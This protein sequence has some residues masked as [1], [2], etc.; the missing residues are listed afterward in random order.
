MAENAPVFYQETYRNPHASRD[1]VFSVA[2]MCNTPLEDRERNVRINSQRDLNWVAVKP[3]H[4]RTAVLCGG[5]PSLVDHLDEIRA[6]QAAGADVFTMNGSSQFLRQHGIIADAQVLAD[7]KP[8]TAELYDPEARHHYIA[9]QC[10]PAMFEQGGSDEVW[11]LYLDEDVERLFPPERKAQGGYAL[12]GGITSV[13]HCAMCLTWALGYR[14]FEVFG[15]DSSNRGVKKH[16]YDQPMN[17]FIPNL[18]VKWAGKTYETSVAMR[19]QAERMT[20][21]IRQL[22]EQDCEVNVHGDGLLPAMINFNAS[23]LTE[24]DKYR[25]LW[26]TELY[27]SFS[28]GEMWARDVMTLLK[29]DSLVLDFGCGSGRASRVLADKGIPVFLMDFAENCRDE[30][31]MDL[32]FLQWDLTQPIPPQAEY[33]MCCDV[34]EHIH[35]DEVETVVSNIMNA[36]SNV[37]FSIATV[38]DVCHDFIGEPLHLTIQPH[39]W[40]KALLG[41]YGNVEYEHEQPGTSLFVVKRSIQ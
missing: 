35:P 8:E 22:R 28:P 1:L 26:G 33:G 40:W 16:A 34:M 31:A 39:A 38:D 29:P 30:S 10:D 4:E 41:N 11:H 18:Q 37:F 23:D 32:P 2:V 19:A 6:L 20:M 3:P 36:A 7:A 21:T 17:L 9:S 25:L 13:G 12:I 5:G 27:R 24:Q 15:Y 14:H